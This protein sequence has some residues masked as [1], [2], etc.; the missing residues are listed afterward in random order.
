MNICI[1]IYIYKYESIYIYIYILHAMCLCVIASCPFN[2][3]NTKVRILVFC[4]GSKWWF[5]QLRSSHSWPSSN[6]HPFQPVNRTKISLLK[7]SLRFAYFN[8]WNKFWNIFL[9]NS[10]DLHWVTVER[11]KRNHRFNKSKIHMEWLQ[12]FE[13][14]HSECSI[15]G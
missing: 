13:T 9:L 6:L 14:W 1:N 12:A 8:G 15:G 3:S 10:D 5:F 4:K 2:S 7:P 11:N